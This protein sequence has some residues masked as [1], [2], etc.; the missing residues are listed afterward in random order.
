MKILQINKFHYPRGGA[1]RYYFDLSILL[2]KNGHQVVPF[3]VQDEKNIKTSFSEYFAKKINLDKFSLEAVLKSL[4]NWEAGKKLEKL[5]QAE[6]PDIAHLH[7]ISYHL[8]PSIIWVLKK[9]NIPIVQTLHDYKLI[10]PNYQLFTGNSACFGCKKYKYYQCVKNKCVKN[11]YAKSLLAASEMY[12]HKL[13][14]KSYEKVDAFIAPSAYMKNISAEFGINPKKITTVNNFINTKI[15]TKELAEENYILYFGR[16]SQEKGIDI[17]VE[18]MKNVPAVKLKIAGDGPQINQ[19]KQITRD[20]GLD[21][22]IEFVG[23]KFGDELESIVNR[24]MA[25]VVPSVWPENFPFSILESL[26]RGKVVIASRIGG[27]PELI[28]DNINGFLFNPGDIIGLTRVIN[29]LK[30]RDLTSIK[31]MAKNCV[32]KYASDLHYAKIMAVYEKTRNSLTN[33]DK[34]DSIQS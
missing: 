7:N 34:C 11:S 13:I 20:L 12:L 10:C 21:N 28:Q 15:N 5:I 30:N 18:A 8:T 27:I 14:L 3:A 6:K 22:Q 25:V 2:E 24:S 19:L 9:Y 32:E 1:E 23:M 17:L 16:I 4:Y 26:E 33:M 31:I 29:S